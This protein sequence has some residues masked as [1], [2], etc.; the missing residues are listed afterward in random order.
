MATIFEYRTATVV[1]RDRT[2]ASTRTGEGT[3]LKACPLSE[4]HLQM[5]AMHQI[6]VL[7]SRSKT[8]ARCRFIKQAAEDFVQNPSVAHSARQ[9]CNGPSC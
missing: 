2:A 4:T 9:I 8:D 1:P 6:E 5:A 3:E 7:L